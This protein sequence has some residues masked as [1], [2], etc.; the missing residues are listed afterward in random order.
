MHRAQVP[1]TMS[2]ATAPKTSNDKESSAFSFRLDLKKILTEEEAKS[3][4]AQAEKQGRTIRE[5]FLAITLGENKT[6][7]A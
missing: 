3:F 2:H 5:H 1:N 4:K 6:S 7:A